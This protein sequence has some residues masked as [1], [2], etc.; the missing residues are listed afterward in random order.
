MQFAKVKRK[1]NYLILF[2]TLFLAISALFILL[3]VFTI[4]ENTLLF[5][6]SIFTLRDVLTLLPISLL[7]G[8][9]ITLQVYRFKLKKSLEEAGRGVVAS[10]SGVLAG[11]LGSASCT[12]CLAAAF[13]FLGTGTI[14]TLLEYRWYFIVGT[15]MLLLV[16]IYIT[17]DNIENKCKKC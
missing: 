3:P 13:G 6:L 16:S 10:S 12:S 11:L 1:I 2:T 9:M 7:M 15:I 14:L 8:L 17:V 5:Q 4:P